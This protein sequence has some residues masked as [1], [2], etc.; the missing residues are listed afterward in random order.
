MAL[1]ENRSQDRP[2]R[3]GRLYATI[4]AISTLAAPYGAGRREFDRRLDRAANHPKHE[5]YGQLKQMP[6]DI[7]RIRRQDKA[8]A[9]RL[10][11]R[12]ADLLADVGDGDLAGYF[13]PVQ[14]NRFRKGYRD[15]M[16]EDG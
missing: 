13:D 4:A 15:Q 5:M 2:Y 3:Y 12:C 7:L 9:A 6:L 14:Q 1:E 11:K 8:A 16:D 10:M